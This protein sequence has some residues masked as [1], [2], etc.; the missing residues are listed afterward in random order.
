MVVGL[1][2]IAKSSTIR[3]RLTECLRPAAESDAVTVIVHVV[4]RVSC[5]DCLERSPPVGWLG[6]M[7][8]PD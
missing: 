7:D 6:E 3:A 8:H 1:A 2:E 4:N 5:C